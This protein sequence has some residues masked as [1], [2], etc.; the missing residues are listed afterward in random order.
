MSPTFDMGKLEV[1]YY[2]AGGKGG[3][4]RNKVETACRM[5]YG[6]LL[7][8]CADERSKRQNYERALAEIKRRFTANATE[9]A[10]AKLNKGRRDQIG[11]GMRGD[12][13]RTYRFQ[14]DV[15]IDHR[16]KRR[17]KL[18]NVLKGKW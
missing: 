14:D 3:Q 18:K 4:H 1:E 6:N 10:H 8:T 7:V 9:N 12:K 16:T 13:I 5:R 15:V 11:S 17:W 2:R